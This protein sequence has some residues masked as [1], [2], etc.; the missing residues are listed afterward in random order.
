MAAVVTCEY[1]PNLRKEG[2]ESL[3]KLPEQWPDAT[4]VL[5]DATAYE[6]QK[7]IEA[8]EIPEASQH[9]EEMR[10]K[11]PAE[12]N[13]L[14]K[15]VIVKLRDRIHQ[16][17]RDPAQVEEVKKERQ[18]YLSFA[19]ELLKTHPDEYSFKQMLADALLEDGQ[20]DEAFKMF[21]QLARIEQDN[22]EAKEKTIDQFVDKLASAMDK[23]QGNLPEVNRL[24]DELPK[25]VKEKGIDPSTRG[26][27]GVLTTVLAYAK[28][29][30]TNPEDAQ[31]RAG[32]VVQAYKAAMTGLR[33][34]LK[35]IIPRDSVNMG[36][37]ARL[38]MARK[39]YEKAL[40][41]YKTL[42]A[43]LWV[44]ANDKTISEQSRKNYM[45]QYGQAL[46]EQTQ[47]KYEV[48][49]AMADAKKKK[50]QMQNLLLQ[51]KTFR[52]KDPQL[53]GLYADFNKIESDAQK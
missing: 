5:R 43:A 12:A 13:A 37:L 4:D 45:A 10:K 52:D 27:L 17:D 18:M 47:C 35:N 25:A 6:V 34:D 7:H 26:Y 39:E 14:M 53:W 29:E 24:A 16:N 28:K 22:R 42:V 31:E 3:D 20:L 48:F 21:E 32:Q 44:T 30:S 19:R 41:Y 36:G 49:A 23:A 2:M 33:K 46:L 1:L 50:E 38:Y 51:I 15:Q 11:Y 40:E 8:N 9:I